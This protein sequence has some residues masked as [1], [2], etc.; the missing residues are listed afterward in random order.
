M[1]S[2]S[3]VIFFANLF[4]HFLAL[5][6]F[7]YNHNRY[8]EFYTLESKLT[9]RSKIRN[10]KIQLMTYFYLILML[11]QNSTGNLKTY[12]YHQKQIYL[13]EKGW[14]F[15]NPKSNHLKNIWLGCWRDHSWESRTSFLRSWLLQKSLHW[16]VQLS[17]LGKSSIKW[18]PSN[19]QRKGANFYNH[20][21]TILWHQ[22]YLLPL[23]RGSNMG[24]VK[25]PP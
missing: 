12:I 8:S 2:L 23:S 1:E 18:T 4:K 11:L 10:G 3:K 20:L 19:W 25:K 16:P 22:L 24:T 14:T 21:L 5:S 6:V 13:L 9:G 17:E 7:F 15:Y